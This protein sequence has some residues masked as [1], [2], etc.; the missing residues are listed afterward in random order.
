MKCV[1]GLD[2]SNYKTSVAVVCEGR[3]VLDLRR[4]LKV[5]EG[6]RGLRQSDALFQHVQNLPEL[7]EQLRKSFDGSI[8]GVAYS[9]RPRAV[10]GSY[11]PCFTAGAGQAV[12]IAAALDVPVM[13]FSHQ[14]GHIEAVLASVSKRP[15][16]DFLACHFSG[17]TCEVLKVT[18]K[19][20]TPQP[21]TG[22]RR[23]DGEKAFYDIEIVGGTRDISYGQVLD[24]AG[25]A[26]GLP[27]PCGQ[28]LDRMALSA[29]RTT[30]VLTGIKVKDACVHLSGFDTQ[31]RS[32]IEDAKAE[33]IP[34]D[35]L[36]REAF[37][38]IADSI[39]KMLK[40]SSAQ[41]GLHTVYMSGGVSASR[42]LRENIIQRLRREGID[43]VFADAE[44]SS[45]NA[46]G[47]AIL[48]RRYLWG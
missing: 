47:T 18:Q 41:T 1:L 2:T 28:E 33:E 20:H 19:E 17:G 35:D 4:F 13:G 40:Q 30:E 25:V 22:F 48:G 15:E 12:S 23:I 31:L 42:F 27:F 37:V 39:V 7:F 5:K 38:R 36:I 16:G 29:E 32:R 11:M 44:L 43:V 10:E 6:E 3:A 34:V 14:E 45:D 46:V 8:D 26:M 9:S 24:R 21:G